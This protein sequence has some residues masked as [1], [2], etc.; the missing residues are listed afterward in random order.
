MNRLFED[1]LCPFTSQPWQVERILIF[2]LM[3]ARRSRR[4]PSRPVSL[5]DFSR[6]SSC[7]LRRE[8]ALPEDREGRGREEREGEES[9][10]R[11]RKRR[12]CFFIYI[13]I[14]IKSNLR[15]PC[16]RTGLER[17]PFVFTQFAWFSQMSFF[18]P[19]GVETSHCL[20]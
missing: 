7:S 18:F 13:Y 3:S 20:D 5:W 11:N 9:R 2:C 1:D 19:S 17:R 12:E 15:E 8:S 10:R 6:T 4:L 16:D 14:Y